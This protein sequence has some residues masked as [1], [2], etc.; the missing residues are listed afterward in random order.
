MVFEFR[1]HIYSLTQK[2]KAKKAL[3]KLAKTNNYYAK[4]LYNFI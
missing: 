3:A 1:I 2:M 4:L